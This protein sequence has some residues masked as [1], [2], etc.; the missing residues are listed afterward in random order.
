M[1]I[2]VGSINI[3]HQLYP[4]TMLPHSNTSN[5]HPKYALPVPPPPNII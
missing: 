1:I 4:E 5:N 3:K 2:F